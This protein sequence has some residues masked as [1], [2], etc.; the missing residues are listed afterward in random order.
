MSEEEVK[1]SEPVIDLCLPKRCDSPA[2][3][4]PY[5]RA[6]M[7]WMWGWWD[8]CVAWATSSTGWAA[9]WSLVMLLLVGVKTYKR[10]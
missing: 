3:V 1:G 4:R 5:C 7:E 6:G 10:C 8:T 9:A 2:G